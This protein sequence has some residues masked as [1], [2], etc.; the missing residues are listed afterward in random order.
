MFS[1]PLYDNAA[2]CG[3]RVPHP[4]DLSRAQVE[5]E[6]R[7]LPQRAIGIRD[8]LTKVAASKSRNA[9]QGLGWPIS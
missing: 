5:H 9:S 3:A 8:Y 2:M 7:R 6:F 1:Y 4:D